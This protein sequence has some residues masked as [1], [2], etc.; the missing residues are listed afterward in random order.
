MH[1]MSSSGMI[2]FSRA[3]KIPPLNDRVIEDRR[4]IRPPTPLFPWKIFTRQLS[5]YASKS[6]IYP[7]IPI[8][9][10]SEGSL[11]PDPPPAPCL[12]N[13]TV[14]RLLD[15]MDFCIQHTAPGLICTPC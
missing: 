1:R 10:T 8:L 6:F 9:W 11:R 3:S 2:P 12:H 15:E 7:N 5:H 13:S 4:R 14:E